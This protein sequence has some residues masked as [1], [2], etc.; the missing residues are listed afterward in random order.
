MSFP[1]GYNPVAAPGRQSRNT[2]RQPDYSA[3]YSDDHS[4]SRG[5][6]NGAQNHYGPSDWHSGYSSQWGYEYPGPTNATNNY[7]SDH[8]R[9]ERGYNTYAGYG[10]ASHENASYNGYGYNSNLAPH[11]SRYYSDYSTPHHMPPAPPSHAMPPFPPNIPHNNANENHNGKR[12]HS[13]T[14]HSR[15][16]RGR[17][18]SPTIEPPHPGSPTPS[19]IE[20]SLEPSAE[21]S[22]APRKLLVL[23]LNGSLVIRSAR[24]PGPGPQP[25]RTVNPRPYMGS[26]CEFLFH[27][28]TKEWLDV[29]VWSSAQPYS[30]N[31][32][33]DKA[34]G[35]HKKELVAIWARDTLGLSQ[36]HYH[37][38]VQTV[39]DLRKPWSELPSI[40]DPS[41]VVN[42]E[43]TP[44]SH[45]S[46]HSSVAPTERNLS[47]T[48]SPT[49]PPSSQLSIVSDATDTPTVH[50]A[51]TTLLL[52]DSPKKAILQPWN[53]LCIPDYTQALRNAD[54]AILNGARARAEHAAAVAAQPDPTVAPD[55]DTTPDLGATRVSSP[56]APETGAPGQPLTA[57]EA[58]EARLLKRRERKARK[59]AQRALEAPPPEDDGSQMD[60]TLL[61]VVGVLHTLK[62]ESNVAGWI[63]EGRLW[64]NGPHDR[65]GNAADGNEA[66]AVAAEGDE[67]PEGGTE[68]AKMWFEDE[69]AFAFWEGEGRAAMGELG[70][71][72]EH[73]LTK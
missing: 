63:R 6:D 26:F 24:K 34:F 18:R 32:M 27:P 11:A 35:E 37:K 39:K 12:P 9:D 42:T 45:Q 57:E 71:Q 2:S 67:E 33:V 55:S 17:H 44:A 3:H 7:R 10:N 31:D 69:G 21:S 60:P 61:A 72:V 1:P 73:G 14:P 43:E 56:P 58:G 54:L 52:D 36:D 41:I 49:L 29:M 16:T 19:Y 38:K 53:H 8:R 66:A 47:P 25:V 50:S 13:E 20:L 5:Y 22:S 70:I 62:G 40:L 30:V 64:P 15:S 51:L 68:A 46:R 65:P 4:R 48:S 59:R 23:D 28:K